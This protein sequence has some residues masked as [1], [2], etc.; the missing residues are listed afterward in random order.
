[1][2]GGDAVIHALEKEGVSYISGFS[3]GGLNP[4]WPALRASETIRVFAARHERLGVEIADGYARATGKVGVAMTGTGPGA[5]NTLTGIAACYADNVPVLLLMGQHPLGS[6]GKEIQQEVPSTIFD[7]LVKWKGTIHRVEQIP[8]IM[9]RAFTALRTGSPGP[10][11]L[12]LPQDVMSA[13][14]P[15]ERLQ[16]QPVGPGKR[17][18]ADRQDIETAADILVQAKFPIMNAGGGALWADA[19]EE[20]REL[21]ELLSMPVAS[22]LV[23]KGVFPEDH[24][25]SLGLGV[26]PKSRFASGAAIHINRKADAVLA[27][28]NSFR[29]PNATDGRPIPP[30]VKL[31][32]INADPADLNKIYQADV[33]ILADAKLSLRDLIDAVRD[34]LGQGKGGIKEEVV[35]EIQQAKAKWLGEWM[36]TFTDE[37]TPINGYR[38]IYDLM[39][40]VDP[41]KT[42]AIHDAGGS[43]GYLSPFWI[44]TRPRNY[45]GMGGMAAMGW[46]M[47]A[48][49]GAKLGRPDHLVVHLLGDASFGMTG[50]EIET[51]ARMGIPTLTIVVNNGG[52]GGALMTADRPNAAPLSMAALGG[53]FSMVARGLGAY[54]ER[55]EQPGELIPAFKRAIKA[56]EDGQAALVEVIT[57]HLPTPELADDWSL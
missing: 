47:G 22:T 8:E 25:L 20:V 32:H 19:A 56:T 3:G 7:S 37:T 17:A 28:G 18:A 4:L 24:P 39:Q 57:R 44:T 33:A 55:V 16:Y 11:V 13:E 42:I 10:V 53:D 30:H 40:V 9:R 41:D 12:E 43:R 36:P 38:V 2:R 14:G 15:D 29:L 26:Y 6:M 34:R 51:A 21:A 48:A 35:A 49:I 45:V 46:S 23:G 52:T 31:I 5:T 27:V 1:M 54:S 50:M